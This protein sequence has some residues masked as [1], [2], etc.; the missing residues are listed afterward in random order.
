MSLLVKKIEL[1]LI[2]DMYKPFNDMLG[3]FKLMAV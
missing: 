1:Q 2:N 3:L